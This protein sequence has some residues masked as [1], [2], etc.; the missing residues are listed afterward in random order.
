MS[1]TP[2]GIVVKLA[3][4][5]SI[6]D[7]SK[8]YF[9]LSSPTQP[10]YVRLFSHLNFTTLKNVRASKVTQPLLCMP[11]NLADVSRRGFNGPRGHGYC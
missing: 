11:P 2:G 1:P 5:H 4:V 6:I 3:S 7:L 10:R 8:I 9:Y